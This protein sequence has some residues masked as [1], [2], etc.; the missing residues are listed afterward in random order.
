LTY[1]TILYRK[2]GSLKKTRDYLTKSTAAA[3]NRQ[4]FGYVAT[5]KA[6]QVWLD[7]CAGDLDA[8]ERK[9][10][11]ALE[12]WKQVAFVFSFQWTALWPL[13]AVA[14]ERDQLDQAVR[15]AAD[16]LAP[17]QQALPQ[18]V[19]AFLEQAIHTW[20]NDQPA[21]AR[22]KLAHALALAEEINQL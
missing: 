6:N 3:T 17:D 14:V 5:A 21:A 20:Q 15:Y 8:V 7:W 4:M 13:M 18:T 10:Q 1:L 16:L 22:Q 11:Q 19:T 2:K 12:G 9:G